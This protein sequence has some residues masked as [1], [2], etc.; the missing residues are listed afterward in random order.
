MFQVKTEEERI[1]TRAWGVAVVVRAVV[2]TISPAVV[3]RGAV[4]NWVRE[5]ATPPDDD[6]GE[7]AMDQEPVGYLFHESPEALTDCVVAALLD[8]GVRVK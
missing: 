8:L 2:L 3:T 5:A 1:V 6:T 4:A 7:W